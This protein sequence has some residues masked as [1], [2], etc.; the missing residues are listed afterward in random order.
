MR[1]NFSQYEVF[2]LRFAISFNW[3]LIYILFVWIEW[4]CDCRRLLTKH[5]NRHMKRAYLQVNTHHTT[6]K[7]HRIHTQ[8]GKWNRFHLFEYCV[9]WEIPKFVENTRTHRMRVWRY[10]H[11]SQ[12]TGDAY[13][14]DVCVHVCLNAFPTC[15]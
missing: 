13:V 11:C 7:Y 12:Y 3:I 2:W 6:C 5:S 9:Y 4:V 8:V 10:S 1:F 14:V 15:S